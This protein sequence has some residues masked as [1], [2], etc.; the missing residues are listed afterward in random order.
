MRVND[1]RPSGAYDK[2]TVSKAEADLVENDITGL[3]LILWNLTREKLNPS[4]ISLFLL[5]KEEL[6]RVVIKV[7]LIDNPCLDHY[8]LQ[9]GRAIYTGALD[10][11]MVVERSAYIFARDSIYAL[12]IVFGHALAIS[13]NASTIAA[14]IILADAA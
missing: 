3:R 10:L 9:E 13:A 2:R 14:F 12:P 1:V 7:E 11:G 6:R 5:V 8:A 4:D